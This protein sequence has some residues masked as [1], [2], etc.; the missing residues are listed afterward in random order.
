[1]IESTRHSFGALWLGEESEQ[2]FQLHNAGD[3]TLHLGEVRSTCGCLVAKLSASQEVRQC[4]VKQWFRY[5]YGR[6][7]SDADLCTLEALNAAFDATQGDIKELLV[8][9]TQTN[10]FLYRTNE[11][12]GEP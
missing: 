5:G 2:L 7:E 1:M 4:M 10:A 3:A 6:A 9:L 12:A 11:G 8:T